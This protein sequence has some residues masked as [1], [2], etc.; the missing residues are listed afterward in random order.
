LVEGLKIELQ[1]ESWVAGEKTD[2]NFQTFNPSSKPSTF[3]P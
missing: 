1:V 2:K 3:N